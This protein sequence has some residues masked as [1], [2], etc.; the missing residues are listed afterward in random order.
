[1]RELVEL[2]GAREALDPQ[3]VMRALA[4]TFERWRAPDSVE[5]ARLAREHG[6]YSPE[7]VD[8]GV[9]QALAGWTLES[10]Q[11]LRARELSDPCWIP[12]VTAVWLA[13]SIPTAAFSALALPLLAG[14]SVYAKPAS[15]DPVSARLF[16]ASLGESDPAVGAALRIGHDAKALDDADAVVAHGSDATIALLRARV[17]PGRPFIG[18]GHKVSLAVIGPAIDPLVAGRRL[19]LDV[20]LWDGRGCLSPAWALAVDSPRG[21]AAE[22]ARALAAALEELEDELPRGALEPAEASELVELRARAAVREGTRLEM[23]AGASTWTV[24]LEAGD[25]RPPAGSFRFL[26]VVPV[27]EVE[28]VAAFCAPLAPHLSCVGHAGLAG[29]RSRL[30]AIA[31][32]AGA[33]RLCP[34]GRMQAPPLEWNHDGMPP[35]RGLVRWLDVEGAEI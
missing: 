6:V 28:S 21:R 35:L 19:A 3:R 2:A 10:L 15:A 20:A 9:R 13:G 27:A 5:R 1:V 23:A 34:L 22:V 7:V 16:A 8:R 18:Y 12:P 24:A 4:E 14:S 32:R 25:S 29:E 30:A 17:G 26:S 31:A 33:S 11:A